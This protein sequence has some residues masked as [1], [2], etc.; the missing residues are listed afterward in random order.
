MRNYPAYDRDMIVLEKENLEFS[1]RAKFVTHYIEVWVVNDGSLYDEAR[2]WASGNT[3]DFAAF[4]VKTLR[5]AEIG[6]PAYLAS[7]ELSYNDFTN[8]RIHWAQIQNCLNDD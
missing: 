5:N 2:M 6:T 4:M 8:G 7:Q 3:R 1:D